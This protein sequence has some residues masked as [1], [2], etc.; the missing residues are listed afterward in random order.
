MPLG[1]AV[2]VGHARR[3]QAASQAAQATEATQATEA[4]EAGQKAQGAAA[5][6]APESGRTEAALVT[7]AGAETGGVAFSDSDP[8]DEC[9]FVDS[10]HDA[11]SIQSITFFPSNAEPLT[12]KRPQDPNASLA[13]LWK[14]I[15]SGRRA[16]KKLRVVERSSEASAALA[17][18]LAIAFAGNNGY[19]H[20]CDPAPIKFSTKKLP[21]RVRKSVEGVYYLRIDEGTHDR[22][23]HAYVPNEREGGRVH[24]GEPGVDPCK[25]GSL[26]SGKFPHAINPEKMGLRNKGKEPHYVCYASHKIEIVV[27]LFKHT[28]DGKD[29]P[30]SEAELINKICNAYPLPQRVGDDLA[31][32]MGLYLSLQFMDHLH[33]TPRPIGANAFKQYPQGGFLLEPHESPPCTHNHGTVSSYEFS[34]VRGVATIRFNLKR[35]CTTANL[36]DNIKWGFFVLNVHAMNPYLAGLDGFSATS[37][38]FRIKSVM[39][40]D[41]N[42]N[43]RY[44][45]LDD[46]TI[47]KSP[48]GDAR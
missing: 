38:P 8:M 41:V 47:S 11:N 21:D 6:P 43:D 17:T 44:V 33:S 10:A 2:S 9:D 27:R 37:L 46:G 35:T 32:N 40:N 12:Y 14:L 15:E 34:M 23:G 13:H 31:D 1:Q 39:H 18:P 16:H 20:S 30:A 29:V 22:H 3:T 45:C 4:A 24:F 19:D 25:P 7:T 36:R 48:P 26:C 42:A 5:A 28:E